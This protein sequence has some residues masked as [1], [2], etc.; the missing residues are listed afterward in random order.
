MYHC[1]GS[2]NNVYI[3]VQQVIQNI[4]CAI[5]V[6]LV[7]IQTRLMSPLDGHNFR[8]WLFDSLRVQYIS[9][10]FKQSCCI[11]NQTKRERCQIQ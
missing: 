5:I 10:A 6:W 4:I 1:C 11:Q 7:I 8:N 2:D 3:G 9:I